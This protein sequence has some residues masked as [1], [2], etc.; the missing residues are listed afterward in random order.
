[1]SLNT[2]AEQGLTVHN[3]L[4]TDR[5]CLAVPGIYLYFIQLECAQARVLAAGV[6]LHPL[7][8]LGG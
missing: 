4:P 8:F 1:M 7:G 6:Y 3:F 5:A 2:G